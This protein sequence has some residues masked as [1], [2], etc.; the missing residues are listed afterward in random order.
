MSSQAGNT[1]LH[2]CFKSHPR[3]V[4]T[5]LWQLNTSNNIYSNCCPRGV[6]W[7]FGHSFSGGK[8]LLAPTACS[9]PAQT[10]SSLPRERASR[11]SNQASICTPWRVSRSLF[12]RKFSQGNWF[13]CCCDP[14]YPEAPSN[15]KPFLLATLR[16]AA[17]EKDIPMATAWSQVT[18][19]IKT[20]KQQT[21]DFAILTVVGTTSSPTTK[22]AP[23]R[24]LACP[25]RSLAPNSLNWRP[26]ESVRDLR[27]VQ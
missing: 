17:M 22:N 3:Y 4:S 27:D 1:S 2:P 20:E 24:E 19:L 9:F 13:G 7:Y 14:H 11:V 5:L 12:S 21:R 6:F 18:S 15:W 8:P 26:S 25:L 16:T 10:S 23:L